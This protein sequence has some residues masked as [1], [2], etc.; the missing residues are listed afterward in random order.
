[1]MS[2]DKLFF[3]NH[4]ISTDSIS[5]DSGLTF[6][7]GRDDRGISETYESAISGVGDH[8]N[9][10]TTGTLRAPDLQVSQDLMEKVANYRPIRASE[11]KTFYSNDGGTPLPAGGITGTGNAVIKMDG[12]TYKPA[13]D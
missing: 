13:K 8:C 4:G 6:S 9:Q 5:S 1:M 2:K 3:S 10:I 12:V 7:S 11:Y